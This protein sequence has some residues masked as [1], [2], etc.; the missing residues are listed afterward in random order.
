M[1]D[2]GTDM[3]RS[4]SVPVVAVD[5]IGTCDR[6]VPRGTR[7]WQSRTVRSSGTSMLRAMGL[8]KD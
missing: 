6:R 3:E 4:G 7:A 8:A 1:G 2:R 5:R